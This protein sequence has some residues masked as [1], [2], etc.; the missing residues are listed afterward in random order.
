MPR[1][2]F[3]F[4]LHWYIGDGSR[5]G[6]HNEYHA[7]RNSARPDVAGNLIEQSVKY[8]QNKHHNNQR[9]HHVHIQPHFGA[10]TPISV[11]GRTRGEVANIVYQQNKRKSHAVG[12]RAHSH[13]LAFAPTFAPYAAIYADRV[14]NIEYKDYRHIFESGHK[15]SRVERRRRN[16]HKSEILMERPVAQLNK[17]VERPERY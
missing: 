15:H 1:G 2:L 11:I 16:K 14:R 5:N 6:H 4:F 7:A 3:Q 10:V 12:K 8:G 13:N 17:E 9:E